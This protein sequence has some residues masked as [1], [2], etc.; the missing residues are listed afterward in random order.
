M[1]R[2]RPLAIA[3]KRTAQSRSRFSKGDSA[4][5][6]MC[7]RARLSLMTSNCCISN[8]LCMIHTVGGNKPTGNFFGRDGFPSE[9]DSVFFSFFLPITV[10]LPSSRDPCRSFC[11]EV[12]F[13]EP[14]CA[15]SLIFFVRAS[16]IW[17]FAVYVF[18]SITYNALVFLFFS[19]GICRSIE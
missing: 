12:G 16:R 18:L 6:L 10:L 7:L 19:G 11:T 9:G 3:E 5:R 13:M 2:T 17:F 1:A 15:S 14:N 4:P 8:G